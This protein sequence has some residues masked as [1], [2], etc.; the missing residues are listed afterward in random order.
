[1]TFPLTR[2]LKHL[3]TS[4]PSKRDTIL[5]SLCTQDDNGM[6]AAQWILTGHARALYASDVMYF[7]HHSDKPAHIVARMITNQ[8]VHA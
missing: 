1:M 5:G 8:G 4:R 3:N 7:K 6:T 2:E